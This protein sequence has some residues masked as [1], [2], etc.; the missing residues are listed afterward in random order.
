[1]EIH[2]LHMTSTA[3]FSLAAVHRYIIDTKRSVECVCTPN[4]SDGNDSAS[5]T[6]PLA[7]LCHL[8]QI[9]MNE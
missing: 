7:V 2:V 9:I 8:L 4:S 6:T 5:I 1:M 3:Y